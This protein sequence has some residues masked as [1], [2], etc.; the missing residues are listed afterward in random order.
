MVGVEI[1]GPKCLLLGAEVSFHE[2]RKCLD[3]G[4]K[5][6]FQKGPKCS[7]GAEVVGAEVVGAEVSKIPY[8]WMFKCTHSFM[9]ML[10][11]L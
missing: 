1:Q 7:I 8:I 3:E 2:G 6:L 4:P 9:C 11:L 5:C 10:M